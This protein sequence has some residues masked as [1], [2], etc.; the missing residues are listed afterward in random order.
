MLPRFITSGPPHPWER[1]FIEGVDLEELLSVHNKMYYYLQERTQDDDI[2]SRVRVTASRIQER[3][4]Q[5]GA[6][7]LIGATGGGGSINMQLSAPSPA[8]AQLRQDI[9]ERQQVQSQ[10]QIQQPAQ[11]AFTMV[12]FAQ[13]QPMPQSIQQ[14]LM[15]QQQAPL[16][17][18][19]LYHPQQQPQSFNI[20]TPVATLTLAS[21]PVRNILIEQFDS[22]RIV[23]LSRR[24]RLR[25]QGLLYYSDDSD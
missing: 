13:Q 11:E 19:I 8:P 9:I 23:Y 2:R 18:S 15:Y 1:S 24:R 16:Q 12:P 10:L 5:H 17:Q 3:L 7:K 25:N 21:A 20:T 14:G 6:R 4:Q 22:P